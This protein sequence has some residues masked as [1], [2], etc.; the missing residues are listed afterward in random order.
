MVSSLVIGFDGWSSLIVSVTFDSETSM[1]LTSRGKSSHLS[2]FLVNNPVDSW[3]IS[4][5]IMSRVNQKDFEE[6]EGGVLSNPVRVEDSKGREFLSDSFLSNRLIVL[7]VLK[8]GNTDGLEFSADD[9]F[10][11]RSLSVTSSDL[12]SVDNITLL[13]F[14]SESS[15]LLNS[16]RSRDSVD[17]SKLSVLPGSHS[18]DELHDSGLFLLPKFLDIFVGSHL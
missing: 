14:V 3:V 10:G 12:D 6:F 18:L 2:M 16:G 9:S 13:G 15:G 5:G 17:S 1:F 8:S 7:L 4:D 11:S